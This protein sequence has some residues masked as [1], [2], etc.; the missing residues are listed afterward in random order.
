MQQLHQLLGNEIDAAADLEILAQP[1]QI[2][3]LPLAIIG[4]GRQFGQPR[5]DCLFHLRK[6]GEAIT[7]GFPDA[8]AQQD[9][10][11]QVVAE[12]SHLLQ[13]MKHADDV[14]A[15][16]AQRGH[17][18][19]GTDAF[20][21]ARI[22]QQRHQAE[23]LA[24]HVSG[25]VCLVEMFCGRLHARHLEAAGEDARVILVALKEARPFQPGNGRLD[26]GVRVR[27]AGLDAAFQIVVSKDFAGRDDDFGA[28]RLAGVAAQSA[29]NGGDVIARQ[30][31][32]GGYA[33][34]LLDILL[35]VEQHAARILPITS[36][37][38]GFLQVVFK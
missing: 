16:H 35:V 3:V 18:R 22:D 10:Q 27:I 28:L 15:G 24:S 25:E 12:N 6:A 13:L 1:S 31:G 8:L 21:V 19:V 23:I 5:Q 7:G 37:A 2:D 30:A 34:L 11:R 17:Q 36:G 32:A 20:I 38:S 9:C 33:E 14:V 4:I 26:L 29:Q